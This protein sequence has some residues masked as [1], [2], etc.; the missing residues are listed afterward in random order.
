MLCSLSSLHCVIV[1]A[2]SLYSS[3]HGINLRNLYGWL[4]LVCISFFYMYIVSFG[5]GFSWLAKVSQLSHYYQLCLKLDILLK[6]ERNDLFMCNSVWKS[7]IKQNPWLLLWIA[8]E[9]HVLKTFPLI[10]IYNIFNNNKIIYLLQLVKT[11]SHE[12]W[13]IKSAEM[14]DRWQDYLLKLLTSVPKG[15]NN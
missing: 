1:T 13:C 4:L 14:G 5:L 11:N 2:D 9:Q 12:F 15:I 10:T 6:L 7:V 3:E 8:Q